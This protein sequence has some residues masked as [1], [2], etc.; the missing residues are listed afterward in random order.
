MFFHP[1]LII[2]ILSASILGF[3][4]SEL[5][6]NMILSSPSAESSI[7]EDRIWNATEVDYIPQVLNYEE[8]V[9][10]IG[11]PEIAEKAGI[12]GEVSLRVLVDKEGNY[13][14][15]E[16][17]NSDHPILRVPCEV[18]TSLLSFTPA[19][20]NQAAVS[21]WTVVEYSFRIPGYGN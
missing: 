6:L 8:V 9:S 19:R 10:L 13:V 16:V 11:Y 7:V 1:N 21:C 2:A 4:G 12:Q 5:D 18:F 15:H 17:E 20:K 14:R 3:A